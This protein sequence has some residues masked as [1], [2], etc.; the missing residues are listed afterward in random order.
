MPIDRKDLHALVLQTAREFNAEGDVQIDL[1]AGREA[2]LFGRGASIDS[3]GLVRF[4]MAVE[5]AVEVRYGQTVTIA[6][7]RA[8]SQG[9]SPFRTLGSLADY[10]AGLLQEPAGP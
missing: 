6:S 10:V 1:T 3:L 9:N 7:D 2:I 4:I 5:Q 8:L